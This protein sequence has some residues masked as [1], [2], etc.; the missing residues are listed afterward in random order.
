MHTTYGIEQKTATPV[1]INIYIN[2]FNLHK[3][4]IIITKYCMMLSHIIVASL[5][6]NSEALHHSD[7]SI[8]L[9]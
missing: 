4:I 9:R 2:N 3:L 1:K 5:Y 6:S 7:F 8:R